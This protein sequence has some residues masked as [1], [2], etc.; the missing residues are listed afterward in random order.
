MRG[1]RHLLVSAGCCFAAGSLVRRAACDE[2]RRKPRTRNIDLADRH[3]VVLT[4]WPALEDP[5]NGITTMESLFVWAKENGY[6][7]LEVSA[8]DMRRKFMPKAPYAEVVQEV[9][10][11]AAKYRLCVPGSLYHITD[12]CTKEMG[13]RVH[14]YTASGGPRFDLDVN[15]PDFDA[16]FREKVRRDGDMGNGYINVHLRLPPRYLF[17][18]GEYRDDE[19]F[20]RTAAT[21]LERIV[22]I[23][24]EE[25]LNCYIETHMNMVS[26]DP[27]GFVRIMDLCGVDFEV[28]LDVS[29]YHFRQI[30]SGRALSRIHDRVGHHHARLARVLGDLSAQV[31]D[32]EEDW[33]QKGL[34]WQAFQAVKPGL[35]RGLSSRT[36]GGE[37][38]PMHVFDPSKRDASKGVEGSALAMDAA[39]VPLIA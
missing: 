4:Q 20:C 3:R 9:R 34:T 24:H 35:V 14:A 31:E 6:D 39:L 7:G 36:I 28:N 17:T 33:A 12:G 13:K 19:Q 38:G 5:T 23:C 30:K 37:S 15:D 11:L 18:G 21:R 32:P 8:D 26:E 16:A 22:R 29:H 2:E 27:T 1:A 25:G 10:R